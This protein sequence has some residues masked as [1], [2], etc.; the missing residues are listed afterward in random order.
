MSMR[1]LFLILMCSSVIFCGCGAGKN[2]KKFLTDQWKIISTLSELEGSWKNQNCVYEYPFVY[3]N[4]EYLM[5]KWNKV[6]DTER[7]IKFVKDNGLD[8]DQVKKK[9]YSYLKYLYGNFPRTDENGIE[10]G[11]K[12]DFKDD[13]VFYQLQMMIPSKILLD[14]R[15]FFKISPDE[16]NLV[17]NGSLKLHS[18]VFSDIV[19]D[20]LV[21]ERIN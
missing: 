1:R 11:L 8:F 14:N 20:G 19:S 10:Q 9:K 16:K 5:V 3:D 17:E 4:K 12:F 15:K 18:S 21:F 13:K 7:W 2:E 6:D